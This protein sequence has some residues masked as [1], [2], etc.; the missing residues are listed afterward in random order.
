M[1]RKTDLITDLYRQTVKTVTRSER[2]WMAFLRMA[3]WQYKYPFSDQVCIYAQKPDAVA[4][5]EIAVWNRLD[6]W[7]NRGAHG[8]ALIRDNGGRPV[9]SHVFDV[10]D[11]HSRRPFELWTMENGMEQAITEAM[12]NR[13]GELSEKR[14]FPAA[15]LSAVGNLCEDSLGDYLDNLAA[16]THGSLLAEYDADN[17]RV[18]LLPILKNSVAF[19][20][21]TRAGYH[22]PSYV[23]AEALHGVYAFSTP[24]T[25]NCLGTATA[26]LSEI[27]LREVE[28]VVKAEKRRTV[29]EKTKKGYHEGAE[30]KQKNG[31]MNHGS[32]ENDLSGSG[33]G[34]APEPETAGEPSP[35][36]REIR[37][38]AQGVSDGAPEGDLYDLI[39]REPSGRTP[40]GDRP[41]STGSGAADDRADGKGA[42][43]ERTDESRES[44]TLDAGD[45]QH[46]SVG[47]GNRAA[48]ADRSVSGQETDQITERKNE[49]AQSES[50][51]SVPDYDLHLGTVVYIGKNE[52]EITAMD[53]ARVELFDG[54]LI[55]L[56]L[57]TGAFLRRLRD[58]PLNDRLRIGYVPQ[59]VITPPKP[60][61]GRSRKRRPEEPTVESLTAELERDYARWDDLLENGGSDPTW[62]DGVNM[63]LVQGRIVA[64]R[65]ILTELC[66]D[67]TRPAILE[68]EE[69]R[70]MPNDYMAKP[71]AIRQAARH[72][73]EVYRSN[74]TYL[75]CA[76]QAARIPAG[77]LKGSVIP[78][79]L[80]YVSGLETFI[81]EDD[82]VAMR[83]HRNPD[84]YL[85]SFDRCRREI[86]KL[87]PAIRQSERT[88]RIY[89]TLMAG[90]P[91]EPQ[92]ETEP[93]PS[94]QD[95][96]LRTYRKVKAENPNHLAVIRVGDFYEL[97]GKD[98]E[99][100]A[101]A[102]GLTLTSRGFANGERLPMCGFPY[103]VSESYLRR[104]FDAGYPY[105]VIEEQ[106][107]QQENAKPEQIPEQKTEPAEEAEAMRQAK[108]TV[109][110][111]CQE[112]YGEDADF[113]DLRKVG[114]AYSTVTDEELEAQID[115]DLVDCVMRASVGGVPVGSV[116][117]RDL[118]DMNDNLL[119]NLDFSE[120]IAFAEGLLTPELLKQIHEKQE[121]IPEQKTAE[122]SAPEEPAALS[123][124]TFA[125][126]TKAALPTAFHPEVSPG[127]RTDYRLPEGTSPQ[128]FSAPEKYQANVSAIRLLRQLESEN[129]LATP[130]EQTTLASYVGWGGLAD[131]FDPANRHYEE[132]K[133]LLTPEEYEAAKESTLTAFYTPPVVMKAI[134][135]ALA[136]MGFQGGNILE[137]ACGVGNF[138][139]A[140]PEE[141][142]GSR[143]YGVELDSVSGRIAQQLYQKQNISVTGFENTAFPDSF[144]DVAVGN[145]PFG[146]F[147]VLD[148][149]YNKYNFLIHD[150]FFAKTLDKVRPGGIIAMLTSKGTMDKENPA[151]RRYLA[152]RADLIG[153]IRLPEDTFRGNAGTEAVAD[154]L[155]FQK[156]DTMTTQEPDW[157]HLGTDENGIPM[158]RYFIDHPD[159]ILGQM[160][161]ES[162]PF[163]QRVT[164]KPYEDQ[165]LS[166]LL[167]EAIPNLHAE[168]TERADEPEALEDDSIPADPTVRNYSFTLVDGKVYYRQNSVMTPVQTSMTGENRIKGMLR[169]RD[170]TRALIDAQLSGASDKAVRALQG[171][172]N[173]VYDS[174]TAKYGLINSRA[175]ETVFSDDSAY[176]LLCSLEI[177]DDEDKTKL[178]RKADLFTKRTINPQVT[179]NHVDTASEALAV[180]LSERAAVDL[181]F[182]EQLTG[183]SEE[184]ILSELHGVLFRNPKWQDGGREKQFLTAD[185][186]L[187]GNVRV[188]LTEA[189]D[190]AGE[191]PQYAE[192]VTALESVQPTDL[193]PGE[194]SVR[195]GS[196][197]VPDDVVEQFVFEL[198]GTPVWMRYRMQ[199]RFVAATAQWC[200]S[201]KNDDR[202]NVRANSTY[203][204]SR[205]NAYEIIEDTLNLKDVRVFDYVEDADGNK[206]AVLNKKETTVAQG[207]QEE[208]KR[209][210][211]EWIWK[212][213]E[214]R[215]EL[216]R[217]Y[218]EKFNS[219]RPR[220]YNGD[221]IRF[222]GMNPEI[223][224]RKHQKDAVARILYG[225]NSLLAHV[226][227]A[228]KT[229]TMV[230][231]AQES[232][233]L[234]LCNKSMIVVPNHLI[235]QW[236]SEYLQL[237]PA[238]NLLVATKK[239]FE[240]R[241]RKKFC[242]R[243]AT[244]DYDAIIIGHSQFEKIPI[245]L[246][247]QAQTLG[248]QIDELTAAIDSLK[249]QRGER[250]TVK[251][252]MKSRKQLEAKLKKLN[253]QTRKDDV[254]CFEELGVDRLFVDEAHFYKNLFLYTK[255]RNVAG[256]SQ[257]EAQKSSDLF[258]KCRYLDEITGGKGVVFATGTPISNSMVEL[259]TMQRYLQ[260]DA[261]RQQDMVHFDAWASTYGETV[262][263][264]E[265]APDGSGYRAKTRFAKFSN[266]P[267]MMA[268]FRQV[269]DIQTADM[270]N[271]P[272]PKANYHIVK[273]PASEIQKQLVQSFAERA[274]KI[275]AGL[276][277]SD[278]DNM[279]LITNDGRKAAL[280]QRLINPMLPDEPESKVNACV[281]NVYAI[282]KRTAAKRSAQMIFCDLSIPKG[283]G[284]F[285]VY[286][287]IREKLI[288]KGIP[289]E[290]I[291]FIHTADTDAKKKEL[292]AK[293]RAGQV[294]VLMGSTFKMGAGTNCQTRL[295]A[296]HDLDCPW[297]PSD[298]EQRAGRIVRQGN[299]NP[300]VDIYRYIAEGTFDAYMY[301]L[302]ESK[303][304]FTGQIMTSKSPVR[305]AED[306]D[307]TVLSYAELKAI[308]SGNPKIIEKMQLDADV[309]KLRLRK[310]SHL[311]VRYEL[312]DDLRLTYPK[313]IAEAETYLAALETDLGTVAEHTEQTENGFSPMTI[314]GTV[315]TERKDAGEQILAVTGSMTNPEPKHLGTYRGMEME[316]GFDTVAREFFIRCRGQLTHTAQLGKDAGG[317]IQRIDN[318]LGGIG[319]RIAM[320]QSELA[321]LHEQVEN[322]KAQ[323]AKP[324]PDEAELTEKSRRLDEL[325]AE[326]NMDQRE[327]EIADGETPQEETEQDRER[328]LSDR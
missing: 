83:R 88:D 312:E 322:A 234:G 298:L 70:E 95:T 260:Y 194:I 244:G 201:C 186:Y 297:R 252:L 36:D 67:G 31:G 245:S 275:H 157:V 120:L 115:L 215:E 42:W 59:P 296:L 173:E 199:V 195:L 128:T 148:P 90:D 315:Y 250:M 155:F 160:A 81:R 159:M 76:E 18:R 108:E 265:L 239:D 116:Q 277:S 290:E 62:A 8:I 189:R 91:A 105:A 295:I 11:T 19:T 251:Q 216:T 318:C 172:L 241:N 7:V 56:E 132:L 169:L 319:K 43:G 208:I 314:R 264:I 24:D 210:F 225:G 198:L 79:I 154:I 176:F 131:C 123:V 236:A 259:Y 20:V 166:D 28:K 249:S 99:T 255:M 86:E 261:L 137:P 30:K 52:C 228:G 80:G 230:A 209:A 103:H 16:V 13:F 177:L 2:D 204:T 156:R 269:A 129:R 299:L 122:V 97:F 292:F 135:K 136:N 22:A 281:R 102:L 32:Y 164:C 57:E 37:H 21:L 151:V 219:I 233:R 69:P 3:A 232:K 168:L 40:L 229:F 139:G 60:S 55:P 82:L 274:E 117:C 25:V 180:S 167:D 33:N 285:N 110:A 220:T 124:P 71:D 193:T 263:A 268:M 283:D 287:D 192:H 141:M 94:P 300:E 182:M 272:V 311:S 92:P 301:Q 133:A 291:A 50:A 53:G 227:G 109:N 73:L 125:G 286:D 130:E 310:A 14:S 66:G 191:N 96:L 104:L 9:L 278:K 205:I 307:E 289:P 279:L 240:T 100:A 34:D 138:I 181:P 127:D 142:R 262:T 202:N 323:L 140:L 302:M 121:Q 35:G 98:A 243:I 153:A 254:I 89:E 248:E 185:E 218:N 207:K 226:V 305:S 304:R 46:Q 107:N 63:N 258:L 188:K 61:S 288:A 309:A 190:A 1:S 54:T 44:D 118:A 65:R 267:E 213:P 271:L 223:T 10:T 38:G 51:F 150:Y 253:D 84:R 68:R 12:E 5:A 235:E 183:K 171:E 178:K 276:V 75:W 23:D 111:F 200:I 214:R 184:D 206:K 74:P 211:A 187:S 325:N 326:L 231:A 39:D 29:D 221:H 246:I 256:I 87:L 64:N 119:P 196:T 303:Q 294:R 293:V 143:V 126:Q 15:V 41:D 316:I 217:L 58:N 161:T 158:N 222:Y 313:K 203:G 170:I 224:L 47:G 146:Q 212:N 72:S 175:N 78:T 134:Y 179:V 85:D 49:P 113:S 45:E 237:Y 77:M 4:C 174:F 280:D 163:G 238:A 145:V 321:G 114:I 162:G 282:W 266:S 106:D 144:F 197:W 324:F 328:E 6:R 93:N 165:P 147:K 48:S 270:L 273:V 101:E 242:S 149:K 306:V 308:A 320:T 26:D 327:N 257:T 152:Q 27:C 247:R 284:K 112:E 317:I 17:L